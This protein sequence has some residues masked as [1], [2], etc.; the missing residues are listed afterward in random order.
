[1]MRL[2]NSNI[3]LYENNQMIRSEV[4]SYEMSQHYGTQ[5]NNFKHTKG[6]LL[7]HDVIFKILKGDHKAAL[8][9]VNESVMSQDCEYF[10]SEGLRI[11]SVYDDD[12]ELSV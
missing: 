1:M 2:G 4:Q 10:I 3:S 11:S 9:A 5:L 12:G 7:A 6:I 8:D